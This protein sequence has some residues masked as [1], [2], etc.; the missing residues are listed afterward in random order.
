LLDLLDGI[1]TYDEGSQRELLIGEVG[2]VVAREGNLNNRD[3]GKAG[4]ARVPRKR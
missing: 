4:T 1:E 2:D 3:F